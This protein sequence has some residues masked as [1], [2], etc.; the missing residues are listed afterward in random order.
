MHVQ[1]A[2]EAFLIGPAAAVDSYLRADTILQVAKSC[3][4]QVCLSINRNP[5]FLCIVLF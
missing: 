2:D 3:G 4:A 5:F 1:M